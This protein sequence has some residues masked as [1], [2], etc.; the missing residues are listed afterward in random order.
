MTA[1]QEAK[2]DRRSKIL[3]ITSWAQFFTIIILF[4]TFVQ[5]CRQAD[6]LEFRELIE[7]IKCTCE[8]QT[9]QQHNDQRVIFSPDGREETIRRIVRERDERKN[10]GNLPRDSSSD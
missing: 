7:S 1:E 3:F 9:P 5:S 2:E 4:V 10:D 8:R 6:R